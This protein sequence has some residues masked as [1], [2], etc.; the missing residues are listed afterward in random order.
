MPFYGKAIGRFGT[1]KILLVGTI[2]LSIITA[3]YS[4]ANSLW[5]FYVLAFINGIF[6]NTLSFMVI[7]ILVSH[8]FE[9]KRGFATGI[10]YSGSAL[11]GAIM[12]PVVSRVIEIAD[13]RFAF[14]FMGVL[15]LAVLLPSIIILIK[16]TPEKIGLKPYSNLKTD[17]KKENERLEIN[18]T[19]K[20]ALTTSRFWLLVAA[21]FFISV[22]TGATNTHS[23]P[24]LSDIGYSTS[25]VSAVISL[26]MLFMTLGKVFLGAIYDRFG[27]MAGNALIAICSIIFPIAALFSHIPAV[28]WIYAVSLGIASC[29]IS[30]PVSILVIKY[31]GMKDYPTIFGIYVMIATLG[32]SFSVPAMGAVYDYTGSYRPAWFALLVFSIIILVCLISVEIINGR[33][34][35]VTKTN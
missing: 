27:S 2:A 21:F 15:G 6:F 30:V 18:T 28:P 34:K 20:E 22:F 17:E 10:A 8:W 14:L 13:W 12:V 35:N 23:A 5:H 26:F 32:S 33:N 9:D 1:K 24:Y 25:T 16:E 4:L 29:G 19:M 3:G 7:G 31:F 11:G